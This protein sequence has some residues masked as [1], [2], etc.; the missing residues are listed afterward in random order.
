MTSDIPG[1]GFSTSDSQITNN[2][3]IILEALYSLSL[4]NNCL[5]SLFQCNWESLILLNLADSTHPLIHY[6]H[7]GLEESAI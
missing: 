5:T 4:S 7:R 6:N 1:P 3:N 2:I